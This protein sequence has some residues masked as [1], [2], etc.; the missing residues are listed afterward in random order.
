MAQTPVLFVKPGL[1]LAYLASSDKI[2]GEVVVVGTRPLIVSHA[3]D[4]SL[5]PLGTVVSDG[6]W[7]I[8]QAAEIIQAGDRVY[9]DENGTPVTGDALSGA[10][11]AT[12]GGNNLI[13]T[14]VPLQP[15]GTTDT[16]ATDTYV[17][18]DIDGTSLN[19]ASVG[20]SMTADDI[21]G[22]DSTLAILGIAAAQGGLVSVTGG[23]SSTAGNAGG[24]ASLIGGVPGTTSSGGAITI[25][26]GATIAG[27]GGT[28]GAVTVT[29]GANANTT[30]GAGGPVTATG[31]AGKGTGD[32]GEVGIAGGA[33][34]GSGDGGAVVVTTGT[35]GSGVA[36]NIHLRAKVLG[37][38]GTPETAADTASLTD[39]QILGGILV[40][41]PTSTAT[42]TMRTGTQIETALG[43]T[44]ATGDFFDLTVINLGGAGDIIT[45]A[46]A[47]G[48]T[49]VGS[50]EIDDDG[51]DVI[52]SGT[53]RF[54]RGASNVFVGYRL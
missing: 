4:F 27:V 39:A 49:F 42:Y 16:A 48:V 44:L 46:V 38:Q 37:K 50:E 45:M 32:G 10:A 15:N 17:R 18:V 30:N 36:G 12:A 52:S 3:I 7:D 41:T 28:G 14:A 11:T 34:A 33:A 31:G 20:G 35:S 22:S 40:G 53:F 9:W 26:G 13:G 25:A 29:G 2:A 19:I 51:A 23:T 21:T 47:S 6:A 43:G 8:P 54:V 5:N 24:A 1:A